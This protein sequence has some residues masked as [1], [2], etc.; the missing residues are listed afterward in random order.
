MAEANKATHPPTHTGT[1]TPSMEIMCTA[2]LL[3]LY[4]I[5]A[6]GVEDVLMSYNEVIIIVIAMV[7]LY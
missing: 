3:Q 2:R 4:P 1:R 5:L 7:V 6:C